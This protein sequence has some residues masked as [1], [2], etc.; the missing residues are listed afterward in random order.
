VLSGPNEAAAA[1]LRR[2]NLPAC[3]GARGPPPPPDPGTAVDRAALVALYEAT[4][5]ASLS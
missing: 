2:L 3:A 5:A 4:D 1:H